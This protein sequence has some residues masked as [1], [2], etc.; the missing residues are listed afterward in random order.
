MLYASDVGLRGCEGLLLS[1]PY[2]SSLTYLMN[3]RGSSGDSSTLDRT[4]ESAH[5]VALEE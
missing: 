5:E 3:S 4:L 1:C 2:G